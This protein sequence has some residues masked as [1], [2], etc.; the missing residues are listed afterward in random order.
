MFI[1][2]SCI[3]LILLIAESMYANYIVSL[4]TIALFAWPAIP[5]VVHSFAYKRAFQQG[6]APLAMQ[7]MKSAR[8]WIIGAGIWCAV[9]TLINLVLFA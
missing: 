2:I 3:E 1:A 8:G 9:E 6:N 7:K 4:I 5:A